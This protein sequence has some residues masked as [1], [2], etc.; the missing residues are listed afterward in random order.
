MSDPV[1]SWPIRPYGRF[2]S[3]SSCTFIFFPCLTPASPLYAPFRVAPPPFLPPLQ[4][5]Q[6]FYC[7]GTDCDPSVDRATVVRSSD[8]SGL[9]LTYS[10]FSGGDNIGLRYGMR[11]A[12]RSV[13][14]VG[15]ATQVSGDVFAVDIAASSIVNNSC[16]GNG[17]PALCL[18]HSPPPPC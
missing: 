2:A 11:A 10:W 14:G 4:G 3:C 1:R 12:W 8:S 18:P 6:L 7:K 15:Q 17:V 13:C 9:T 16:P 5:S